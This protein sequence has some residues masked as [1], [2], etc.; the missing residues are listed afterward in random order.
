LT[1]SQLSDS[2]DSDEWIAAVSGLDVGPSGADGQ[3]QMLVEYLTGESGG[4]EEQI[5]ASR[6]SRLIIAGDSLAPVTVN[7]EESDK[8]SV[9]VLTE[10]AY[11]LNDLTIF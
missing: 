8:K 3:L 11:F 9:S 1:A 2:S 5:G 4:L 10:P 6:I 7:T